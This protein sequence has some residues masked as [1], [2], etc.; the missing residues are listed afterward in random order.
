MYNILKYPID[1]LSS[2]QELLGSLV[3]YFVYVDLCEAFIIEHTLH[4]QLARDN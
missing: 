1:N 3:I 4:N 2:L